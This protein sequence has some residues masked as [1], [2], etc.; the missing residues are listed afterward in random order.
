M[1]FWKAGINEIDTMY[2]DRNGC[3]KLTAGL[4]NVL[5]IVFRPFFS[6]LGDDQDIV[7]AYIFMEYVAFHVLIFHP[8]PAGV[9]SKKGD[10]L[11]V[12]WID[13]GLD[14]LT[15]LVSF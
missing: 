13:N 11:R 2:D 9:T 7:V 14:D 12:Y 6:P 3:M 4:D 8:L 15:K 10:L 5:D 1:S